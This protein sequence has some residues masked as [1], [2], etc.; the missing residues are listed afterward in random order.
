VSC[1]AFVSTAAQ[2]VRLAEVVV[3]RLQATPHGLHGPLEV[4]LEH[5]TS[6]GLGVQR[7]DTRAA[8][9]RVT[10]EVSSSS[11]LGRLARVLLDLPG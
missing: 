4:M 1:L 7:A 3:A 9:E 6:A 11:K 8:L 10:G 2:I 5:A